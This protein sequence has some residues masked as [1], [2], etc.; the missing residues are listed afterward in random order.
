[1]DETIKKIR[2]FVKHRISQKEYEMIEENVKKNMI[3]FRG[4]FPNDIILLGTLMSGFE[5]SNLIDHFQN[6]DV[7]LTTVQEIYRFLENEKIYD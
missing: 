1:M 3:K 2:E 4:K 6:F 5:R 7:P